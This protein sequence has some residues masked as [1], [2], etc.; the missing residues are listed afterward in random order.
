[1][2]NKV[3]PLILTGALLMPACNLFSKN[4]NP[5]VAEQTLEQKILSK[6]KLEIIGE[7]TDQVYVL[8]TQG[9]PYERGFQHGKL[10]K[11]QVTQN[12]D[13]IVKSKEYLASDLD[14][15]KKENIELGYQK[16]EPFI[17]QQ[18]KEEMQ[19]LADGA[20]VSIEDLRFY[21]IVGDIVENGCSNYF[22]RGNATQNKEVVQVRILDFP[23]EFGV[24]NYPVISVVNPDKG[25][26]FATIGWAGFLGA[27]TGV[28]SEKI[29]L[30]E[31][32]GD[33]AVELY[34]KL[35]QLAE[36]NETLQGTPMPFLLREILQFDT[37]LDEVTER[38]RNANRTNCYVYVIGDGEAQEPRA[39]LTDHEL[40]EAFDTEKFQKI[41]S[42]VEPEISLENK[43][44]VIFGGHNNKLI[45]EK[46]NQYYGRITEDLIKQD[47]NP[48]LAMKG[49]LQITIYNLTNMTLQVANAEGAKGRAAEQ[50]YVFL[51]LK[52]AFEWFRK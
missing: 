51:D 3:L 42:A 31:M 21:Q 25:H 28:S 22:L 26:P 32:R 1:M 20:G 37:N 19:G 29:A 50:G 8:Y 14:E 36:K 13:S 40:F 15:D 4:Q 18:F 11:E 47:F 52:N 41:V 45:N 44:D 7:G 5:V 34:R 33:R 12:I 9:T 2:K 38:L 49:N 10:L 46:V 39:Y 17:S 43:S 16:M 30:G 35:N 6:A 23:L 48:A 24:Q 27:V